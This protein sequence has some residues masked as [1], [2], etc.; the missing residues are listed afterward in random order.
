MGSFATMMLLQELLEEVYAPLKGI[1]D[2]TVELYCYTIDSFGAWLGHAPTLADLD[3]LVVARFLM[4]RT[5]TRA[6][7]TAAKDRAQ[8]RALWEFAAR[9]RLVDKWPTIAVVKVPERVPEAWMIGEF[10]R[11]LE[12]SSQETAILDG[13][14]AAKWW[15]ALLLVLFDTAE[16]QFAVISLRWSAVRGQSILFRAEDRK[17]QRRDILRD[18]SE[19][20]QSAL[21][22]IRG[23]R[24]PDDLVFPWPMTK[25]YLWTRMKVI[26]Q[27]AGLPAGRRDKFHKIRRTTASYYQQ[28]GH[29]AQILL[30]HSS[31]AVTRKYLDPRIVRPVSAPS[32]IPRPTAEP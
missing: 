11:L 3:E 30:D 16:R 5:R 9:R 6:A 31:P 25:T 2:R 15:R 14:P 8:L 32:V 4:H 7:A 13:I 17:G 28:A 20:T 1:S 27:R 29:S 19:E 10:G 22:D 18:I 21:D 12:A 23:S 26:L 24:K